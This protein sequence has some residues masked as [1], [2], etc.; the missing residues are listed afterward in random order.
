[1]R[2]RPYLPGLTPVFD[3]SGVVLYQAECEGHLPQLLPGSV[4]LLVADPPYSSGG[5]FKSDR[6]QGVA[7]KYCRDGKTHGRPEF[8]GDN[9]D[10]RSWCYWMQLWLQAA[11]HA[12]RPGGYV[13]LFC[14]WR[15]LPTATDALQAGGF[16]W[17]GVIP[18]DKGGGARAPHTGYFRHQAEYVVWGTHGRLPKSR[19]GGP[20]PGVTRCPVT[21]EDKRHHV[22]PKPVPVLQHLLQACPPG[23]LVLDPFAGAAPSGVACLQSGRRWVGFEPN[24]DNASQAC[25]RL[26]QAC[27][28]RVQWQKK[29]S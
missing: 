16:I 6:D 19:H 10:G 27:E 17:R 24:P 15:Q 28:C 23:G 4:D 21:R 1:M 25:H 14:D 18:W 3:R 2:N 11:R 7:A 26:A 9:R 20:W 13:M 29:A 8:T 12:V 22:T 5:L